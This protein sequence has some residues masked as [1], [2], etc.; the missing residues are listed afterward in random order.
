MQKI[1]FVFKKSMLKH[2][3]FKLQIFVSFLKKKEEIQSMLGYWAY[4]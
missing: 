3:F 2:I 4:A 1:I